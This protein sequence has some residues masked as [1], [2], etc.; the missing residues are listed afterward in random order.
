[1]LTLPITHPTPYE[2]Y[3]I[4]PENTPS[5]YMNSEGFRPFLGQLDPTLCHYTIEFNSTEM[6]F[7]PVN[8]IPEYNISKCSSDLGIPLY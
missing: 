3:I 2:K 1:M 4:F 8:N 7:I 5:I 6:T